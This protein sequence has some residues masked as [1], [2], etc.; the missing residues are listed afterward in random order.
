MNEWGTT[1]ALRVSHESHTLSTPLLRGRRDVAGSTHI[2][3]AIEFS[4]QQIVDLPVTLE[5]ELELQMHT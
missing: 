5:G 4:L 2:H 3:V 1:R